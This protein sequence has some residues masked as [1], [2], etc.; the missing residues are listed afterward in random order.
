MSE[1]F[2]SL[3]G[4][5]KEFEGVVAVDTF[6]LDVAPGEFISFLGPSGCGKTTTLR[7]VAG[8]EHPSSGTIRLA[9]KDVTTTK[10]NQRNIGM[11]FQ[12]YALFPNMTV[13]DNIGFG[14][15]VRREDSSARDAPGEGVARPDPSSRQGQVLSVRA[16]RRAATESGAG[17]GPRHPPAALAAGRAAVGSRRQDQ[18]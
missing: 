3:E 14:L 15:K 5:R 6:N 16:F 7:M 13:A 1:G 9:G 12:S 17:P 10:P 4:V 2:L 11:V 18:R 8:F